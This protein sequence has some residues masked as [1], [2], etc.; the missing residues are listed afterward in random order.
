MSGIGSRSLKFSQTVYNIYLNVFYTD[1]WL[2]VFMVLTSY[3]PSSN[4]H[5]L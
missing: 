3:A 4:V 5:D 2:I 1:V